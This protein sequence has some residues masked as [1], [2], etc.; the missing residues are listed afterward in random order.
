MR[1]IHLLEQFMK[2]NGIEYDEPFKIVFKPTIG[3]TDF[4]IVYIHKDDNRY[5]GFTLNYA[6]TDKEVKDDRF[7][8]LDMLFADNM[9][10]IKDPWK[11]KEGE[12]YW[13]VW[14]LNSEIMEGFV[15][16]DIWENSSLDFTR[17]I[18]GN[19][20]KTEKEAIKHKDDIAR[21]L[22]GEPL[23]KWEDTDED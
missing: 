7:D 13:H 22:R 3:E 15:E 8:I 10:I 11:P 5:I 20:F 19:C 9:R 4:D 14:W 2:E 6:D 17:Y 1:N 18:I 23:I 12:G 16:R 21:V